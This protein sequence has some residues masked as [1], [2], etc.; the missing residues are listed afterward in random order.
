VELVELAFPGSASAALFGNREELLA[1]WRT[2][3]GYAVPEE[4]AD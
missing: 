4:T 3:L 1:E 2:R